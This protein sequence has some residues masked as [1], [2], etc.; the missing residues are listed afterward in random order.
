IQGR[1]KFRNEKEKERAK[2]MG[3]SDLEKKLE[4]DDIA[5]GDRHLFVATGVTDGPLLKG[6]RFTSTGCETQ[7]I[8][9]RSKSGTIR[10]IDAIHKFHVK[11][12]KR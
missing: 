7:S 11:R 4:M 5:R 1:F 9:M 3:I 8:V 6:V 2:E 10:F 12:K